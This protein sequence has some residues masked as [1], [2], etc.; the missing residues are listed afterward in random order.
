[1][2]SLRI[3]VSEFV[4]QYQEAIDAG[5]TSVEAAKLFGIT[6]SSLNSRV[7]QLRRR[8]V[9]LPLFKNQ[10]LLED[11]K[12]AKA[13]RMAARAARLKAREERRAQKKVRTKPPAPTSRPAASVD[14]E[15]LS[16]RVADKVFLRLR[17]TIRFQFF[18]GP[19]LPV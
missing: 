1:M 13:E 11:R 12:K 10:Q 14:I 3:N 4:K 8:G 16:D 18:V 2:H 15:A 17:D 5:L 7:K 6:A 9:S 19:E